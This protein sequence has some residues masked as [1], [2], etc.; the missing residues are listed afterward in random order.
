MADNRAVVTAAVPPEW[1]DPWRHPELF[2]GVTARRIFAYMVDLV[3]VGIVAA[4][5]WFGFGVLALLSL[6]LLLPL[7]ALAVA[8]TPLAYHSFLISSP[9]AATLGMRV[10]GVHVASVAN[11]GGSGRPTLFQAM[12]KTV[13]FYGSVALTSFLVLAVALFNPRRR[14]LHDWLAGTVVVN[15]PG[16]WRHPPA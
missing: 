4:A 10:M 13:A 2:R 5:V 15:D 16:R 1:A 12:I 11:D 7:Q 3:V 9:A 6:G 14:T 8:L